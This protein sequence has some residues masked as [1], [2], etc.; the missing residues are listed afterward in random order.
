MAVKRPAPGPRAPSKAWT[1]AT[2]GHTRREAATGLRFWFG[3]L[4]IP[5]GVMVTWV[6]YA[7]WRNPHLD[8]V[9]FKQSVPRLVSWIG[10][11]VGRWQQDPMA[12]VGIVV[13]IG[14]IALLTT[15][16]RRLRDYK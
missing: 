6:G 11:E 8:W 4:L 15:G 2:A 16:F 3:V 7:L 12:L 14:G 1:P 10:N 13:A 5:V 9:A